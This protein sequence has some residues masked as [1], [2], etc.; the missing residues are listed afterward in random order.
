VNR[1]CS[2]VIP[3][4]DNWWLTARTLRVLDNLRNDAPPFETIVVDNASRDE[5]PQAIRAFSWVR[6]ERFEQNRNFAGAC[7]AGARL[8]EAPIVLFLNNDAYPLGD[9]LTPLLRAFDR[10]EVAVAGGALFFEDG[11]TQCAGF[12]M[13][14]NAHWHYSCRNL[15]PSLPGVV[16]ARDVPAVSGAAMAVRAKPFLDAGGFDETFVNGFE[17]VD[18]CMRIAE[19]GSTIVYVSDARFAHYE[20]ASANRYAHEAENEARFYDRWS[21]KL[22]A[23][24]RVARGSVGAIAVRTPATMPALCAAAIEDLE[25][26]LRAFGHPIV[27]GDVPRWRLLD[28]RYR[29]SATLAWLSDVVTE[30]GIA[31][32]GDAVTPPTIRTCGEVGLRVPLLPAASFERVGA[33][34]LRGD[35]D[36]GSSTIAVTGFDDVPVARRRVLA[37]AL[38]ALS[39][40]H[41]SLRMVIVGAGR[42]S[43]DLAAGLGERAD[44]VDLLCDGYARTSVAAVVHVGLTD[45]VAFGNVLLAQA[46]VPSVV[47]ADVLHRYFA[48]DVAIYATDGDITSPVERLLNDPQLRIRLATTGAADA[49]RRFSPRRSAIRIVDLLC[50]AR[51]GLERPAPARTNTPL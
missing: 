6:Y 22:A 3:V 1:Q 46:D 12:T 31:V 24:P 25:A 45:A 19:S 51:F 18:F 50:A 34:P 15:P 26:A 43:G 33:L 7:N 32:E 14:P 23:V 38:A 41:V 48:S 13:L 11:V 30:P 10:P 27:R 35:F 16:R 29:T 4:F 47:A 20:G 17:D 21:P 40:R 44:R 2:V 9:A 37:G 28:A 36:A 49:R 42:A 39:Q 5:T 8:A